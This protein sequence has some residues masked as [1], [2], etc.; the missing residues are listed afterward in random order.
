M[1]HGFL[2]LVISSLIIFLSLKFSFLGD[3]FRIFDHLNMSSNI[4]SFFF[5]P[6][7]KRKEAVQTSWGPSVFLPLITERKSRL[8]IQARSQSSKKVL[9]QWLIIQL[10]WWQNPF[11]KY[12]LDCLFG[13]LIF[14]F[15]S[16][17]RDYVCFSHWHRIFYLFHKIIKLLLYYLY[18]QFNSIMGKLLINDPKITAS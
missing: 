3:I 12:T 8:I 9:A 11:L 14:W 1:V 2:L 16:L 7:Q 4:P 17:F 15:C 13:E 18:F 6:F 5:F 10:V